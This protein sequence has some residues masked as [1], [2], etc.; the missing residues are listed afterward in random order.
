[1]SYIK[2]LRLNQWSKNIVILIPAV[3]SQNIDVLMNLDLYLILFLFSIMASSTYIFNDLKDANQDKH[4]PEKKNRPIASGD[5]SIKNALI[6]GLFLA[7]L[8]FTLV[9]LIQK[10]LVIYFLSYFILTVSYSIKFKY[11]K[12]LDFISISALFYIRI[13]IGGVGVALQFTNFFIIFI[14]TNLT[15]ISISKKI[16]ILM[17]PL[18]PDSLKVKK[19]LKKV[20]K[21]N[22][23]E[24]IYKF[25]SILSILTYGL[26]I[27]TNF[28]FTSFFLI[29]SI[30]SILTLSNFL[31]KFYKST[32]KYQTENFIEWIIIP[33][34]ILNLSLLTFASL[35]IIF[36]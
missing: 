12:Y 16:S 30:L 3:L 7:I 11:L 36:N 18:I 9:F 14:I 26:W 35:R 17:N 15:L 5:I 33:K 4:H 22:E 20:Y 28:T 6:F 32:V 8:S 19:H 31:I 24:N 25:L 1:M 2:I 34:N 21:K 27:Y 23:L 13:L 29:Y 10:N